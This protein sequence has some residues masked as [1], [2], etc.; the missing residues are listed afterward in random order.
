M[1]EQSYRLSEAEQKLLATWRSAGRDAARPG[2]GTLSREEQ[3]LLNQWRAWK[4]EPNSRP[5]WAV[6]MQQ[7]L[8][9]DEP[10]SDEP[11]GLRD[12]S[13]YLTEAPSRL[14]GCLLGGAAGE[15]AARQTFTLGER[16]SAVLFVL[17]GLIRGHTQLRLTSSANPTEYGLAGLQRWLHTHG[18]A[19]Q[20]CVPD[21]SLNLVDGW[22]VEQKAL[23]SPA[24]SDPIMLTALA[25]T[26]A[27]LPPG[28][29][30]QPINSA[31]SASAIPLGALSALWSD[32]HRAVFRLGNE[33]AALTHGDPLGHSPAGVLGTA[34]FGLLRGRALGDSIEAGL[35]NWRTVGASAVPEIL[36]VAL[37]LGHNR[38][39]GFL[40]ARKQI[41]AMG[42]GRSGAGTLA[43]AIR[44]ALTGL[45]DFATAIEVA[46][47]HDGDIA[48][49]A[50][51]CGQLLGTL[52][53]PTAIPE[54]WLAN[55]PVALIECIAS[56]AT[57]EFGP[58]PDHGEQWR[59]RYPPLRSH[60]AA[61][62]GATAK[63]LDAPFGDVPEDRFTGSIL[64]A[65][66]GEAFGI[67]VTADTWLEIQARHGEQGLRDYVPAGHPSGRLGSDTQIMLFTLEGMI[68]ANVSRRRTA[69]SEPSRHIQHAYQRWLHTQHLSWPRAAGEFAE[70]SPEP[71]GWLVQQRALF[72]T[73]NPGRTMMRTLIAFAKGQQFMGT[74]ENPVSDSQG[75]AAILRAVPATL[76]SSDPV[77]VFRIAANIAALTHGDPAAYLSAGALSALVFRIMRGDAMRTAADYA[78]EQVSSHPGHEE[79][80]RCLHTATWLADSGKTGPATI[81]THL[82]TGQSAPEALAI[83]LFAALVSQGD[84]DAGLR[85]AV[86]HSGNSSTSGAICGSLVGAAGGAAAIPEKWLV[87]L[88]MAEVIEELAQDAVLEFGPL[89]NRES[90]WLR[91]YPPT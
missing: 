90:E 43:I 53:G 65:A 58:A 33:L 64:A 74:T 75:S 55:L 5:P 91:R 87:S 10:T 7:Q 86:N 63:G 2:G 78:A 44:A 70:I 39:A 82:G 61:N 30:E 60:S 14:L 76:W 20:D 32:D 13:G 56:D 23:Q 42:A 54:Q 35:A 51:V 79:V 67:P 15:A 48:T 38:P 26:A 28:A 41:E 68:R 11:S 73:R 46:A 52:H 9:E 1:D 25:R 21:D 45:D 69:T 62:T 3:Q 83:G 80:V 66:A 31:S 19:W 12:R 40:P 47:S 88:E 34:V 81:E 16:T 22:I 84:F 59:H 18:I 89:P 29:P 27:G 50:M 17:D 4:E 36:S 8:R 85:V 49:S 71:D 72:Q 37:R 6:A 77:E 24:T 57:K